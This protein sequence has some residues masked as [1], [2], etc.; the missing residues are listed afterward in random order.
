MTTVIEKSKD[1]LKDV[2]NP[3]ETMEQLTYG[4]NKFRFWSWGVSKRVNVFNKGLL[5]YVNARR[6]KGYI[7]I[8]LD[9]SDT[10]DVHLITPR[11]KVVKSFEGVY[12]DV[13]NQTIDDEIENIP[14]NQF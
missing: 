5:L 9:W 14:E 2:L 1:L 3:S 11:G 12:F 6:F 8:A 7:L 13:L 10:Y 4:N